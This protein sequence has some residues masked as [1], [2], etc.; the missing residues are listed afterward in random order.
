MAATQFSGSELFAAN[1]VINGGAAVEKASRR[2][3]NARPIQDGLAA[4][5]DEAA[6]IL[7]STQ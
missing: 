5:P 3:N 1:F 4:I 6:A 7:E 2:I